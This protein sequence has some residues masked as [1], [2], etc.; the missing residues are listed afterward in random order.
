M[1]GKLDGRVGIFPADHVEPMSR[2]EARKFIGSS[3]RHNH[4]VR[5]WSA[6]H[7]RDRSF[8]FTL[9]SPTNSVFF[10]SAPFLLSTNFSSFKYSRV[11]VNCS[12]KIRCLNVIISGQVEPFYI[13]NNSR[14]MEQHCWWPSLQGK[15]E[16]LVR[17]FLAANERQQQCGG[18]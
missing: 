10:V 9:L 4:Q 13:K 8:V 17:I 5:F 14:V 3:A 11:W 18:R 6:V 12:K 2:I 15:K 1:F 16:Y 7:F